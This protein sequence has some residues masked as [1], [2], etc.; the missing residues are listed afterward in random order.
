MVKKNSALKENNQ[1][2]YINKRLRILGNN[3]TTKKNNAIL[4]GHSDMLES[5]G[6]FLVIR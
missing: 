5:S 4:G 1:P 2:K 6:L 3:T